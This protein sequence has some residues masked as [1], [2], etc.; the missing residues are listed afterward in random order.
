MLKKQIGETIE[1]AGKTF[2]V[3]EI[4][5]ILPDLDIREMLFHPTDAKVLEGFLRFLPNT[6][7]EASKGTLTI[8]IV[9]E[10]VDH[11]PFASRSYVEGEGTAEKA[12]FFEG[13]YMS[14]RTSSVLMDAFDKSPHGKVFEKI[15]KFLVA[16]YEAF[17][18]ELQKISPEDEDRYHAHYDKYY[19]ENEWVRYAQESLIQ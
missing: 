11:Y 7:P 8:D 6:V 16:D 3:A 2:K 9:K 1:L 17:L 18:N 19:D 13:I 5:R 12:I 4:K 10:I 14:G 15:R